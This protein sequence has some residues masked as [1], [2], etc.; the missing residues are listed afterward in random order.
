[1]GQ[2]SRTKAH[3]AKLARKTISLARECMGGKGILLENKVIKFMM[4]NEA[5]YT[6]EGT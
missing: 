3:C 2:A 6:Y 5:L 4:D 1:M